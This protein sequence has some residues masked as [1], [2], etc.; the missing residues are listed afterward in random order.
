M[1]VNMC[2]KKPVKQEQHN[3]N[4]IEKVCIMNK[5]RKK[6]VLGTAERPRLVVYRSIRYVYGQIIDDVNH[7]VLL[8][9]SNLSKTTAVDAKKAGSKKEAS[10]VLGKSLA[11]KAKSKK[12]SQVVFDRNGYIYH[13]RIKEFAE[14]VREGGLK[15]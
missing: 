10:R 12:I 3:Q 2:V 8:A 9:C 11:E 6:R 14:G 1:P 15:F 5:R 7:K 13:G 4:N